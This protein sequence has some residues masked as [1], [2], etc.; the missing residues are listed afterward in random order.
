MPRGGAEKL[1]AQ[2]RQSKAGWTT[3]DLETVDRGYGFD[4]R[5][6]GKHRLYSHPKFSELRATVTRHK[7]LPVGYVQTAIKQ[8]D[9]L[10]E[11]EKDTPK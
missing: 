9:R 4:V 10:I 1:L 3:D 6:G 2:M 5:E 7:S 11:L 8:I